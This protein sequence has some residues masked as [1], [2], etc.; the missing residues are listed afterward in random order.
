MNEE[1]KGIVEVS[2]LDDFSADPDLHDELGMLFDRL[3]AYSHMKAKA[4]RLRK[5]GEVK[6]AL[7]HEKA[8][9]G[10]HKDLPEWARW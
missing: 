5:K 9:E 1:L 4:M 2:N 8:L 10:I 3:A 7:F 6:A